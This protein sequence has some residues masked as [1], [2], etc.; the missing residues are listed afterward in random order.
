MESSNGM[1]SSM[2]N[3]VSTNEDNKSKQTK[4]VKVTSRNNINNMVHKK[5]PPFYLHEP[6]MT[7][8]DRVKKLFTSKDESVEITS[9]VI[10]DKSWTLDKGWSMEKVMIPEPAREI[11]SRYS[12]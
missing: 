11:S 10:S 9:P 7:G 3:G 2:S 1:V 6:N 12:D 5:E 4:V 8:D